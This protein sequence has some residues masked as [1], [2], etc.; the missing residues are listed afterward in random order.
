MKLDTLPDICQ[1]N[2][3]SDIRMT[4]NHLFLFRISISLYGYRASEIDSPVKPDPS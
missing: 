2:F 3:V 4:C 1:D